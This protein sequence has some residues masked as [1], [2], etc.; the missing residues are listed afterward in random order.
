MLQIVITANGWGHA[1]LPKAMSPK[2]AAAR[3]GAEACPQVIRSE[4]GEDEGA[5]ATGES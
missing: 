4:H 1:T 3:R 5:T 2:G